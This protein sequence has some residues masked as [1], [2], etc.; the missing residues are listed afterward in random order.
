MGLPILWQTL[1]K[2]LFPICLQHR[3][4]RKLQV[5]KERVLILF[6][7]MKTEEREKVKAA[8]QAP[9]QKSPVRILLATDAA[10][11]GI[12]LQNYCSRLFHYEIPWNPNRMEQRNGRVDRHGQKADEVLV[13]HFVGKGYR[14]QVQYGGKPGDLD[15]D[16]EFLMR[17]ALKVETIRED[18]GKVGPVIANQVEEA[19]LGKRHFLDTTHAERTAEPVRKLLKVERHLRDQLK[20]LYDQLQDTKKELRLSPENIHAVVSV[21]LELAGQPSLKETTVEG[22]FPDPS[23]Q[24]KQCPVFHL[25]ALSGA[26]AKCG[27]GLEDPHTEEIRP[28]VF[29]HSLVNTENN[30]VLVHLNH[31]LVQMCLRLLR[32]EIWSLESNKKIHR[33]TARTVPDH[34]L[35][36]PVAVAHARLVVLGGDNHRIHEEVLTAGGKLRGSKFSRMGVREIKDALESGTGIEPSE[37][38]KSHLSGL[39]QN[40]ESSLTLALDA[41]MKERT[42]NLQKALDERTKKEIDKMMGI[43]SELESSILKELKGPEKEEQVQFEIQF[44]EFSNDEKGQYQRNKKAL[45]NRLEQLPQEMIQEEE[46]IRARFAN[47][48]PRMFPVAVTYLIPEKLKG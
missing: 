44:E 42:K 10:S 19:M 9:P 41:R 36:T 31:R 7:G 39:W 35:D 28:I 32:A 43:L 33:V 45:L 16:L 12:D 26:W 27:E 5:S 15:G 1:L 47:P 24:R 21:G 6:G 3:E 40:T 48:T 29:D 11:E 18:L 22:I 23:G 20:K 46:L 34:I 25:P 4:T 17:A 2:W 13:Y 30:V 14:N 38:I 37:K 8:F